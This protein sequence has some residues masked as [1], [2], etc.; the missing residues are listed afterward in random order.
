MTGVPLR[1][2]PRQR[3]S[4]LLEYPSL[5]SDR[6][7]STTPRPPSWSARALEEFHCPLPLGTVAVHHR[8]C[9]AHGRQAV[10]QCIVGIA[11]PTAP[12][13]CDNALH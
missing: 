11:L 10:W 12:M 3:G 13:Q 6:L 8:S 9:P 2:A 7:L 1:V 4:V 5:G